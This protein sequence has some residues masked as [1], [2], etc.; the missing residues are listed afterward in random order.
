MDVQFENVAWAMARIVKVP[1]LAAMPDSR[2]S[3]SPA[4]RGHEGA[5]ASP[6]ITVAENGSRCAC[7]RNCGSAG[8]R[9]FLVTGGMVSHAEE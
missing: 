9:T 4:R 7:I 1:M 5:A 8:S 6:A 3:G 2:M